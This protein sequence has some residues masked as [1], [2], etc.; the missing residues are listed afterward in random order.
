M[1]CLIFHKKN[2]FCFGA[3]NLKA[4]ITEVKLVNNTMLLISSVQPDDLIS[5]YSTECSHL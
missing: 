5:V 2:A 3:Q 4:L 1:P